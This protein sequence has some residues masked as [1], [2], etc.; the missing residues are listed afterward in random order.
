VFLVQDQRLKLT[1]LPQLPFYRSTKELVEFELYQ[2]IWTHWF[3]SAL[4]FWLS[5]VLLPRCILSFCAFCSTDS[6][7]FI[8]E[9]W[10]LSVQ[11]NFS[12]C[13]LHRVKLS[14]RTPKIDSIGINKLYIWNLNSPQGKKAGNH[15]MIRVKAAVKPMSPKAAKAK[16]LWKPVKPSVKP[17]NVFLFFGFA[18]VSWIMLYQFNSGP[19]ETLFFF[20]A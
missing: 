5:A 11:V 3:S 9:K 15:E 8:F 2:L 1:S 4:K 7:C 20:K 14:L 18:F 12:P 13:N 16:S 6:E 17:L 10:N 19:W